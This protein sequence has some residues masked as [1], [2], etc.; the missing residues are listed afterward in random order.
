MDVGVPRCW[1][2]SPELVSAALVG[3]RR[4]GQT[5]LSASQVAAISKRHRTVELGTS[6]KRPVC[7]SDRLWVALPVISWKLALIG[8]S[9]VQYHYSSGALCA[10]AGALV[11]AVLQS[12][13]AQY[14]QCK[15]IPPVLLLP[16]QRPHCSQQH[17]ARGQAGLQTLGLPL[18]TDNR[19][20]S[21]DWWTPHTLEEL[22]GMQ[23]S[24]RG[25]PS[26]S[27]QVIF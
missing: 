26:P 19:L 27:K 4:G 13:E 1:N 2:G 18:P 22:S 12:V 5:T 3:P 8:L 25:F 15:R 20:S 21:A 24:L 9:R 17:H 6:Y 14:H 10:L 23:I 16:Q 7:I 11:R